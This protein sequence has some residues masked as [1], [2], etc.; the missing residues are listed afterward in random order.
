ML[1]QKH[2]LLEM[3]KDSMIMKFQEFPCAL[4]HSTYLNDFMKLPQVSLSLLS[5]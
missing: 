2:A 3:K 1:S 5:L 4:E